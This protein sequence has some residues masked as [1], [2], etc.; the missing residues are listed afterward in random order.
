[1]LIRPIS[2]RALPTYRIYLEF[3]DGIKGEVDLS[4]LVGKGVFEAWNECSF[5]EKVH[6]G[7]HREV[8][9]NDNIELCPDAL[10]LKLTGK[11]PEELFPA[12]RRE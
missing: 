2:V 8:K 3:S 10:Y 9:W 11:S 6:I 4:D 5:F 1:M 7:E 12:L